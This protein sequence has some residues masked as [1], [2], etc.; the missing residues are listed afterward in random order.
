MNTQDL[1]KILED[2][3]K[4]LRD[5]DGGSRADLSGADLS[6]AKLRSANLRSANLSG[7]DLRSA[8]LRSADLR[9]AKLRSADLSGADLSRANLSG[10]DLSGAD[11]SR[12]DLSGADL[13]GANLRSA[14]LSG[15]DLRSANLSGV[16]GLKIAKDY[17]T[18]FERTKNGIYVYKT[19]GAYQAPPDYWRIE[20]KSFIEEVVN[21]DRCTECG[22]G[23]NFATLDWIKSNSETRNLPIWKCLIYW[24]DMADVV[25][26]YMTDGKA[27]C[28]R[29]QLIEVVD[30]Q[31]KSRW[32]PLRYPP[33]HTGQQRH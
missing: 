19:I 16:K 22:S 4:W 10:A 12:A 6:G 33:T 31:Q 29:L 30:E 14:N 23:V 17:L 24:E 11:L 32:S 5:E 13:G 1:Q 8:N 21:P 18:Q 2:H 9:S 26:P 15:A 25:V 3:L 28:A 27:R 20:P 7:A